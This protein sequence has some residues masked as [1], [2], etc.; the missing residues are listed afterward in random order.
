MVKARRPKLIP[1]GLSTNDEMTLKRV[2]RRAYHLDMA[3]NLFGYRIGWSGIMAIIPI[4]G[5]LLSIIFSLL[6]FKIARDVDGGLPIKIQLI[7]ISNILI[8]FLL[9]LI[10]IIGSFIEIIYKANSRNALVLEKYLQERG[11]E[12]L[13]RGSCGSI[14][15]KKR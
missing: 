6:L 14:Y 9:G 3:F 2:K 12:N 8:D 4:V 1:N 5:D 10:P 13:K 7:F 11:E 15:W